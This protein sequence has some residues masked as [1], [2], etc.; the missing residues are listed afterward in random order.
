MSI[1]LI[2][3]LII[4]PWPMGSPITKPDRM[5]GGEK[6][7]NE[8]K[9]NLRY[10][11]HM[12]YLFSIWLNYYFFPFK[13]TIYYYISIV[14]NQSF[15]TNNHMEH[16]QGKGSKLDIKYII[17]QQHCLTAYPDKTL[18]TINELHLSL[19]PYNIQG[20]WI[21]IWQWAH[22]GCAKVKGGVSCS[23]SVYIYIYI[24]KDVLRF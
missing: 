16:M 1:S 23:I 21:I 2:P 11:N 13:I 15:S 9:S 19:F 7:K 5:V 14:F 8:R 4:R 10:F 24:W 3:I 22:P 6:K 17:C 18:D 12:F 20:K